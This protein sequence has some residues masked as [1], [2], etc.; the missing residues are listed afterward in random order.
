ML[1]SKTTLLVTSALAL[2]F[3]VAGNATTSGSQVNPNNQYMGAAVELVKAP[4]G[5][6]ASK[7]LLIDIPK[8]TFDKPTIAQPAEGIY[9][10]GGYSL[11]P[12]TVIETDDGL[13]LFDTGDTK[14]DGEVFKEVIATF[15]DKPVK[16]VIYGH[17][18]TAI[19]TGVLTNGKSDLPIIGHPDLNDVVLG[20]LGNGGAPAYYP[21]LSPYLTGRILTQF[22]AFVPEEGDDAYVLPLKLHQIESAFIPVNTPVEDGQIMDVLGE[23]MQFFTKYGSDDK[24]H[25]T[26]WLPKRK[27]LLT[28]LLWSGPP[29]LYTLRGDVFRDPSNWIEGLKF[30]RSL[31][32]EVLITA[33]GKP[34]VGKQNVEDTLNGYIDGT[35]FVLDQTIRGINNGQGPD[36]LR[37]TV[38]MPEYLKETPQNNESYGEVSSYP[39]A[40]FHHAV[41]WYDNDAASLKPLA[42]IDEANRL[43]ALIGGHDK[44]M[45]A[46]RDAL[47]AKEYSW[48]AQLV[49]YLYKQNPMDAEVR[50]LKADTLRAMSYVTNGGNE[51]SHFTSQALSLEGKVHIPRNIYPQA[52]LIAAKP[53]QYV[54]YFR[55]RL[56]FKANGDNVQMVQ[57]NFDDGKTVG[58]HVRKAVAEFIE[59]P[60][61]Y[62]V[63]AD[64]TLDMSGDT[65]AKIYLTQASLEALV[66]TGDIKVKGDLGAAIKTFNAFDKILPHTN[67]VIPP[68]PAK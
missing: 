8:A 52:E 53:E 9:V 16:A 13:I 65:W 5:A 63:E 18:H 21:E 33:I 14:H 49:N 42:P 26:V 45:Q 11:A 64:I 68:M 20:N 19:G 30:N 54:K 12:I 23:E 55:T 27:I 25:T 28:T 1:K 32:A 43:V 10:L 17:S 44:V 15:S 3:S 57:F 4:N 24:V 37:H 35:S 36:E 67:L 29:N 60:A 46:S 51:R 59:A 22:N 41:G 47:A 62:K 50:Q 31:E 2:M 39:P 66:K 40:I 56:D 48:A 38:V 34:V 61:D 7:Q 58:L 6:I